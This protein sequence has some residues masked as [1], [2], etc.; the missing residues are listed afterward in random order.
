MK[1]AKIFMAILLLTC[2]IVIHA[3][4]SWAMAIIEEGQDKPLF[5]EYHCEPEKGANGMDYMRIYD[6]T[7][8]IRQEYYN[9]EQL[10]YGYRMPE[11]KIF[12]YDYETD[13][14]RLAFDFTLSVGDHFTTYNGIEWIVEEARDTL[15]N[16]SYMGIGECCTK[17]FLKVCSLD[18]CYSDQ[19]LEDFGSFTNHFMI[20]PM[21]EARRAQTLWMEYESGHYLAREISADP[22]F[23]HDSGW[24]EPNYYEYVQESDFYVNCMYEDGSLMVEDYRWRSQNREY[25]CF[26]REGDDLYI[27]Y[28]WDLNPATEADIVVARKDIAYYTGLPA[29]QSGKYTMHFRQDERP[30]GVTLPTIRPKESPIF[31]LQ[32]RQLK[33][34]PQKGI[35]IQ[36]GKKVL[37]K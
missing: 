6:W 31:D 5:R 26:Y 28:K 35:Y 32:G 24:E 30:T 21:S 25:T 16:T 2:P 23:A 33:S 17:R 10:Q 3:Q 36:N 37:V 8:I 1:Q 29:P 22:L 11:K 7:F 9:P 34:A 27:A 14:E 19:W 18:G 4:Q 12:V 20:T 13:E 15:V